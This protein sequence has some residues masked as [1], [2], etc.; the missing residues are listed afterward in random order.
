MIVLYFFCFSL[1]NAQESTLI[2]E[3]DSIEHLQVKETIKRI[4]YV[5]NF[6]ANQITGTFDTSFDLVDYKASFHGNWTVWE[7]ISGLAQKPIGSDIPFQ[8]FDEGVKRI[9]SEYQGKTSGLFRS[10]EVEYTPTGKKIREKVV[11]Q[12][13]GKYSEAWTE[14]FYSSD[15]LLEEVRTID[16]LTGE[17][18][19]EH[20]PCLEMRSPLKISQNYDL[21]NLHLDHEV[22]ITFI[23]QEGVETTLSINEILQSEGS[24]EAVL[25]EIFFSFCALNKR[26]ACEN[27]IALYDSKCGFWWDCYEKVKSGAAKIIKWILKNPEKFL[28][29]WNEVLGSEE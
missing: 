20:D 25:E 6:P 26:C 14:Y 29:W 24:V 4:N 5:F 7:M 15:G 3:Q 23:F 19:P 9:H 18:L 22:N 12:G 28:E 2:S 10:E 8:D 16:G 11:S 13:K 1:L 17:L 21:K 27:Y